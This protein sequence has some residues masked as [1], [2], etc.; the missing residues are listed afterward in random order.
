MHGSDRLLGLQSLGIFVHQGK[1]AKALLE[2]LGNCD[3]RHRAPED[4]LPGRIEPAVGQ[5][6]DHII[7]SAGL[8]LI[9]RLWRFGAALA[10]QERHNRK[11][12]GGASGHGEK[13]YHSAAKA[14][15]LARNPL[16]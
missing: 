6:V 1:P 5:G 13:L 8:D 7:P 14:E 12:G 4:K 10:G 2:P 3:L 15:N 11:V 9:E 16:K